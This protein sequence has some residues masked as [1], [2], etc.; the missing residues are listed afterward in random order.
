MEEM[1]TI[2]FTEQQKKDIETFARLPEDMRKHLLAYGA[3]ILAGYQASG[4]VLEE[5]AG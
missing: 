4:K 1:K 3:G 2:E 5:M